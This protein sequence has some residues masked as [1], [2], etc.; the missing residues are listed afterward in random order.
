MSIS[1]CLFLILG[2]Q[3]AP[4]QTQAEAKAED[5]KDQEMKGQETP[6]DQ[7]AQ[8]GQETPTDKEARDG[9][10][11]P[12]DKEAQAREKLKKWDETKLQA[13]EKKAYVDHLVK[14][15]RAKAAEHEYKTA[16]TFLDQ[17]LE[18]EPT[19]EEALQL[20]NTVGRMLGERYAEESDLQRMYE[21]EIQV[22]IEQAKLEAQNHYK[23]GLGSL[24]DN[25]Y[26]HAI[27]EFERTIE[28][29]KWAPYELG[30]D[31]LRVQAETQIQKVQEAK[32]Q[33]LA[34]ERQKKM[35]ESR[36]MAEKLEQEE[37][38]RRESQIR[39]L[40][41]QATDFYTK[42]RYDKAEQ[43]V[44]QVLTLDPANKIA[45]KLQNDIRD[46]YHS[47]LS[48]KNLEKKIEGWK[49]FQE[50]LREVSI[51]YNDLLRFPDRERWEEVIKKREGQGMLGQTKIEQEEVDSDA[52]KEIK[53]RLDNNKV[54]W[55]F[56]DTPFQEV[57]TVIRYSDNINIVV[58]PKV[59]ENFELQGTKVTLQLQDI[60]LKDALNILL[61]LYKLTYVYKNDVLYITDLNSELAQKKAFPVLH[62]IRDLTGQLK[63][64]PGPTIELAAAQGDQGS[65]GAVF[66]EEEEEGEAPIT[67]ERL[68]ELIKMSIA[69][70]S[71]EGERGYSIAETSGQLLVVH[72]GRTQEEIRDFL[73]DLRSFSGTMVCI[74][75]RFLEVTDDFLERVGV[76]W[77]G[78]GD[79]NLDPNNPRTRA[80]LPAVS[81]GPDDNAGGTSDNTGASNFPSSGLFF[82]ENPVARNANGRDPRNKWDL[83]AR[84]ENDEDGALGERLAA[85]G[86]LTMQLATLDDVQLSAVLWLVKK[87]GRGELLMAPRL[88][89]FN[90][91]RANLTV[92]EQR[93]YVRDFDVEVAQSAYIADPVIG[94]VQ[95]GVV[96]DV[97]PIISNDRKYI[98]LELRPTVASLIDFTPFT[99]TLGGGGKSVTFFVPRIRLQSIESTVR[100]PDQGTLMMGGMKTFREIDRK[101]DIPIL[102]NIPIVSFFFSQRTKVDERQDLL[103]LVTGKIIDLKEEETK[104]FGTD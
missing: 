100:I 18:L 31:S 9:Q 17:A 37:Q 30:L 91:Q 6:T 4:E 2:C 89:A 102:G 57:I 63:D 99:T 55:D 71:W 19:H 28:I 64:F 101:Q 68:V 66:T 48:Q 40:L 25:N 20:R 8:D 59:I 24:G 96:L 73:N 82:Q 13:Q 80:V 39:H 29:I 90:T 87:T 22:K 104:A 74:E 45:R 53:K 70:E 46:A 44:D 12:P 72:E 23:N 58:D 43:M 93:A 54:N 38:A 11:T 62:D 35:E 95:T 27:H 84:T 32:E 98:T 92:L 47:H 16:K 75:T 10:E 56:S 42:K 60:T 85:T 65:T 21:Q 69:P 5:Q 50:D 51:P 26:D 41:T 86:G 3:S 61:D 49:R 78:I 97:R 52:V 81:Q 33:W 14:T 77:R 79:N 36:Q 83:R 103:I 1:I 7:E 88:T 94:T 76:D 15:A 34:A 67:A